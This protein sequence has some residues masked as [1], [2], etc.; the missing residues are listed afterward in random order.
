MVACSQLQGD[1]ELV[2]EMSGRSRIADI[3][4]RVTLKRCSS[5]EAIYS[6]S[7]CITQ[8]SILSSRLCSPL[9]LKPPDTAMLVPTIPYF[10][11]AI[12]ILAHLNIVI[13]YLKCPEGH[14]IGR[15]LRLTIGPSCL[16]NK[17]PVRLEH[18]VNPKL[19][20]STALISHLHPGR[21]PCR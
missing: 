14:K 8:Y 12:F 20:V 3:R 6:E 2:G 1:L 5:R 17:L 19:F 4:L 11:Q 10:V 7:S 21:F 9:F 18:S 15:L 16:C 13:P